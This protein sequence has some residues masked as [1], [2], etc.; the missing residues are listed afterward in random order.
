MEAEQLKPYQFKK[1][2]G[3]RK[4]GSKN[5]RT[6]MMEELVF[7]EIMKNGMI[8]KY[9][10]YINQGLDEGTIKHDAAT[11]WF[12][13]V[14]APWYMPDTNKTIED[15]INEIETPEDAANAVELLKE[16]LSQM[17]EKE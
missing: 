10:G 16:R 3:G 11:N 17:T 4:A 8:E 13:K 2:E 5:K 12:N 1:G 14:V 7:Q 15:S 6:L 9:I